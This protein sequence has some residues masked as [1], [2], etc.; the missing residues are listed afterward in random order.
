[1]QSFLNECGLDEMVGSAS[2]ILEPSQNINNLPNADVKVDNPL[3]VPNTDKEVLQNSNEET[4]FSSPNFVIKT[5][6]EDKSYSECNNSLERFIIVEDAV[7]EVTTTYDEHILEICQEDDNMDTD[8]YEDFGYESLSSP[9][10]DSRTHYTQHVLTDI[11]F[12]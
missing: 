3:L 8:Q 11:L 9:E 7:E 5:E 12:S 4:Q 1:M 2:E 10:Y 6:I